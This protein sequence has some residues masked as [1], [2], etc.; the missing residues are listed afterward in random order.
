[1]ADQL[2]YE[3]SLSQEKEDFPFVKKEM[4]YINDNNASKNYNTHEVVFDALSFSANGRYMD[5]RNGHLV[6]PLVFTISTADSSV[7]FSA[8]VGDYLIGLKNSNLQLI[9][10]IQLE[11]QNSPVIQSQGNLNQYLIF[12]QHTEMSFQEEL[13]NGPLIGYHQDEPTSWQYQTAG[14]Q[15]GTGICN[16]VVGN[17]ELNEVSSSNFGRIYNTG[18][19][20]RMEAFNKIGATKGRNAIFSESLLKERAVNY[21]NDSATA[22]GLKTYYYTCII[23]LRDLHDLFDKMSLAR[24][25]FFKLTLKINTCYFEVAKSA[26]GTLT[27]SPSTGIFPNG[28]NPLMVSANSVPLTYNRSNFQFVGGVLTPTLTETTINAIYPSGLANLTSAKTYQVSLSI[29]KNIWSQQKNF[30]HSSQEHRLTNC[31]LYCNAYTLETN[32][33]KSLIA[34]GQRTIRYTDTFYKLFENIEVGSDQQIMITT[35]VVA[36]KRIIIVPMIA[37]SANGVSPNNLFKPIVSPFASEPAT[38]SPY[39]ISNFQ[40]YVS[41]N[42]LYSTVINYGYENFINEMNNFGVN[43]NLNTGIVSSRISYRHYL[44]NFGYIVCDLRRKL[45]EDAMTSVSLEVAFKITS[46]LAM[47][48]YVFVEQEKSMTV[49]IVN[50]TKLA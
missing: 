17:S 21:I 22:T 31:R 41:G 28:T 4:M 48:F 26:T 30:D 43:G 50:G 42:P 19:T 9:S 34:L 11:Y 39:S 32:Y 18:L 44:N 45:P 1:M 38:C 20:R 40:C 16:N 15:C 25:A 8:I 37:K 27:F 33:E 2:I 46:L 7:D 3:M 13:L 49:N 36:P 47:D 23:R 10:S 24:G 29:V 6:M 35:A 14:S 12:K 5:Y